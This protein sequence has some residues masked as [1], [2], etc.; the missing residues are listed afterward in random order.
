MSDKSNYL[1]IPITMP[2]DMALPLGQLSLKAKMSGGNKLANTE[3]V[4]AA[5]R[6]MLKSAVNVAGCKGEEDVLRAMEA[7]T[8]RLQ[9]NLR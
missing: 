6:F 1:H 9:G 5:V 7:P 3:L 4:R 8:K 2:A